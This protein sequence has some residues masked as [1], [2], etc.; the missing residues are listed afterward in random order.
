IQGGK[1]GVSLQS[2]RATIV[3][4]G[5]IVGG[6]L[7]GGV[8]MSG[9]NDILING[10]STH[11]TALIGGG[12][13]SVASGASDTITNYGTISGLSLTSTTDV[14]K[15]EAGSVFETPVQ[16]AGTLSLVNGVGTLSNLG[17]DAVVV[18]GSMAAA[19]FSGFR[20]LGIG[21]SARF[22]LT[23][24][25][26]IAVGQTLA[27]SGVLTVTGALVVS[28]AIT[29]GGVIGLA[30]HA[31][32]EF[33]TA[34]PKALTVSLQGGGSF[35][36]LKD[37]SAFAAT[38]GGF[39]HHGKIDLLGIAATS[40]VLGA[41]DKLAIVN[42]SQTVATLQLAGAFTGDAFATSSDGNG[43]T[44]ITVSRTA[45]RPHALIAAA[46]ALGADLGGAHAPP[47]VHPSYGRFT[48]A[49]PRAQIA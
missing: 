43:G 19:T 39:N 2:N 17:G 22:T 45:A 33:D 35:L 5:T 48:L 49:A 11:T 36:E 47:V 20:T 12:G 10:S 26:A 15:V 37:S 34:A 41:G 16:D 21:K 28:G 18:S 31:T 9:A 23:G 13:V 25:G 27:D 8:M 4:F 1:G 29:G 6:A 46:A 7:G 24:S 42:G 40:A 14:L 38:I 3:N 30:A 32:A 44:D